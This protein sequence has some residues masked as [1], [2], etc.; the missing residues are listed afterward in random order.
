MLSFPRVEH[1][2]PC[3]NEYCRLCRS[4]CAP[5][6]T[7]KRF[8][9]RAFRFGHAP[10]TGRKRLFS[11][12]PVSKALRAEA[13]VTPESRPARLKQGISQAKGSGLPSSGQGQGEVCQGR[14]SSSP[15]TPPLFR[16]AGLP[17]LFYPVS[18]RSPFNV[19]RLAARLS[20]FAVHRVSRVLNPK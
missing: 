2:P 4:E 18:F 3:G 7:A 6:N 16:H 11:A 12:L 15:P 13:G 19:R 17:V 20:R 1:G 5:R 10:G 9:D 14:A 8:C